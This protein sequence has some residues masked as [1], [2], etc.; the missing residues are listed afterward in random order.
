M[1]LFKVGFGA[2]G[3]EKYKIRRIAFSNMKVNFHEHI[4]IINIYCIH[5]SMAINKK[6]CMLGLGSA[7]QLEKCKQ[8]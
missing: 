4:I 1:L 7:D 6:H 8:A 3:S 5:L 2:S